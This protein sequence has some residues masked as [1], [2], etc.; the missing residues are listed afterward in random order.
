MA[1]N[2]AIKQES[3]DDVS[4]SSDSR[5]ING[6]GPSNYSNGS[7]GACEDGDKLEDDDD[8][9][10]SLDLDTSKADTKVWLVRVPKFLMEKWQDHEKLHGQNLGKVRIRTNTSNPSEQKV[11]N[12]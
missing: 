9:E 3:K 12:Y 11:G 5:G 6:N 1:P 10:D 8:Y 2:V 7:L 4:S